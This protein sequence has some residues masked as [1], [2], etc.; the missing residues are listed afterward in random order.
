V[1]NF[2]GGSEKESVEPLMLSMTSNIPQ[3]SG[4]LTSQSTKRLKDK[5]SR[6]EEGHTVLRY[7]N[8]RWNW[9]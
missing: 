3:A 8:R 1:R 2:S 7:L 9:D 6:Q 4:R 5:S